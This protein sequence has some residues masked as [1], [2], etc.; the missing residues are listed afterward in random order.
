MSGLLVLPDAELVRPE[1]HVR[2]RVGRA[3]VLEHRV[4]RD[5]PAV[6]E[7]P[8]GVVERDA[9]EVAGLFTRHA[10]RLIFVI[11]AGPVPDEAHLRE[12]RRHA[13]TSNDSR[14]DAS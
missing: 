1:E 3:L 6:A 7:H 13:A 12:R 8:R 14:D 10:V 2:Q 11:A 9:A 4:T 5:V